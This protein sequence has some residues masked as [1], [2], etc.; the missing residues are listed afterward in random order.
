M[1]A[2]QLATYK[3]TTTTIFQGGF[4]S[5]TFALKYATCGVVVNDNGCER[6]GN[7]TFN[8]LFLV[9]RIMI[10]RPH[11]PYFFNIHK[12]TLSAG[13]KPGFIHLIF[14]FRQSLRCRLP[15]SKQTSPFSVQNLSDFFYMPLPVLP[16]FLPRVHQLR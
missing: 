1:L 13:S 12:V 11:R 4:I 5:A 14:F 8:A 16:W 6:S 7:G 3:I 2:R 10:S 9:V 15:Y